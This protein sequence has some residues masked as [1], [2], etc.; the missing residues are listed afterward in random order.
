MKH[1]KHAWLTTICLNIIALTLLGSGTSCN[2][3]PFRERADSLFLITDKVSVYYDLKQPDDKHFLP[4][5]LSEVSGLTVLD[6]DRLLC[7]EDET[8]RVY[9]YDLKKRKIVNA[10]TFDRPGDYEGIELID[11]TIYVLRSDGD[12]FVFNYTTENATQAKKI[13]NKLSAKN[14]TEGL[15]FNPLSGR[16][17]IACKEDEDIEGVKAK[18]KAVYEYDIKKETLIETPFFEIEKDDL[19]TFFETYR[20]FE[21]E[22]E[23]IKF[24][25]SGIAYNPVDKYYYV[26]ASVG[27]LMVVLDNKGSIMA[28]YPIA[29]RILHQPEGI[30]FASNG[31][32]YL[33][34]EGEGDKGYILKFIMKTK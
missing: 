28:T 7:V 18:G 2:S 34:S 8:G 20:N 1:I 11:S 19:V 25:P 21:Y 3:N 13:E 27:K 4:Y 29:P 6:N 14:D 30:S 23:R 12:L 33:S 24:E 16:L 17:L 32:L 9:E 31:D 10:I 5:V 26:I 22:K 15:G